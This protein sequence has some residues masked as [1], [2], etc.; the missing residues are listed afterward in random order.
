MT[1]ALTK[2]C[3]SENSMKQWAGV[4]QKK[5]F[6]NPWKPKTVFTEIRW[7][8]HANSKKNNIYVRD[9]NE[10]GIVKQNPLAKELV[11]GS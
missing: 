7:S 2:Y 11:L 4:R 3:V 5:R 10:L 6:N 9:E 8:A 1:H